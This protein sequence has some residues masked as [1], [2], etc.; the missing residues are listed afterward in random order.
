LTAT[1]TLRKTG[2]DDLK[3]MVA[4]TTIMHS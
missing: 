2:R 3:V 1:A 4:T